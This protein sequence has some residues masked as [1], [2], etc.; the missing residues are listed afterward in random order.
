M[1]G[2]HARLPATLPIAGAARSSGWLAGRWVVTLVTLAAVLLTPESAGARTYPKIFGSVIELPSKNL[3]KFPKWGD[4]LGRWKNGAPCDSGTC[5]DKGWDSFLAELKTEDRPTQLKEVNKAMNAHRYILD[6]QNWGTADYWAAPFQFLKKNGDCEDFAISK[7]F[8]LKALGVPIED[9]RVVA[10]QDLN[11]KLGHAVL[12]VYEGSEA[13]LLD[14]Q[15]KTVVPA[16]S[17][18]HYQPVY[19]INEDGWWLHRR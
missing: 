8:A 7:Y 3:A 11:L 18:R 6:Q 13:K 19:S 9:M 2:V 1:L 16:N 17:V 12:V 5:T 4:M 15:I 14:N 10:V